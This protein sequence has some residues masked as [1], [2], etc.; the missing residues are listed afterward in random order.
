[1]EEIKFVI[2]LN[3]TTKKNSQQ[4][5]RNRKTG[6]R[7]IVQNP[8]Y[9]KYE[10]DCKQYIPELHIDYPINLKAVYYR[11]TKHRVDLINLH[12]ALHDILIKCGCILDDNCN[13][14]VSTDGSRVYYDKDNP[15][16]EV[17]ITK[18]GEEL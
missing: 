15:R 18:I 1:M 3:S 16:T 12:G 5:I 14:I 2:P 13:I 9:L 17:T 7:L 6:K 10:H 8:K 4:I 11:K